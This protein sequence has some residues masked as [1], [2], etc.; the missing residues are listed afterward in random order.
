M[1]EHRPLFCAFCKGLPFPFLT[2]CLDTAAQIGGELIDV[3]RDGDQALIHLLQLR[4]R[5]I[6]L[7]ADFSHCGLRFAGLLETLDDR[8]VKADIG[9]ADGEHLAGQTAKR[10][11]EAAGLLLDAAQGAV[12][13][14]RAGES[15]RADSQYSLRLVLP[16]G[17]VMPVR[18]SAFRTAPLDTPNFSLS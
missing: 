8:F 7:D 4:C 10:G 6:G 13:D 12:D 17:R 16:F 9:A 1:A 5:Q 14:L 18:I 11:H 15:R 2:A 3:R